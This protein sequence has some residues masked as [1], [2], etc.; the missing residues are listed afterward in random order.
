MET[1]ED[2]GK[3]R[4]ASRPEWGEDLEADVFEEGRSFSIEFTVKSR[5][6]SYTEDPSA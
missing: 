3:H 5:P 2:N 6:P 1:D 4:G